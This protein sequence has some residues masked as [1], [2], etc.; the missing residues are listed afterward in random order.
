[1]TKKHFDESAKRV[2]IGPGSV[3]PVL[4]N[5][6][7]RSMMIYKINGSQGKERTQLELL[8][9]SALPTRKDAANASLSSNHVTIT[10]DRCVE[11]LGLNGPTA[12]CTNEIVKLPM[13]KK[14]F[15]EVKKGTAV[16]SNVSPHLKIGVFGSVDKA[17]FEQVKKSLELN[18][19]SL[20]IGHVVMAKVP[21]LNELDVSGR[22]LSPAI[23]TDINYNDLGKP[24]SLVVVRPYLLKK[25]EKADRLPEHKIA[26]TFPDAYK[27]LG[28]NKPVVLDASEKITVPVTAEYFPQENVFEKGRRACDT[29]SGQLQIRQVGNADEALMDKI[30]QQHTFFVLTH[31]ENYNSADN[32]KNR[33]RERSIEN[34]MDPHGLYS[35]LRHS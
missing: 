17:V 6:E 29:A 22:S 31:G 5:S 15:P 20:Q 25:T 32:R 16:A 14:C 12:I 33:R 35:T 3:I 8:N 1:M 18:Q 21:K 10:T 19:A 13:I 34:E 30:N 28:E 27:K 23:I 11:R 7:V 24:E 26:M 2:S 4:I 9:L